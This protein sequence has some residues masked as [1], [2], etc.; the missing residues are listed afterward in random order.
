MERNT[1]TKEFP[2]HP[3]IQIPNA[4][5]LSVDDRLN[6][7]DRPEKTLVFLGRIH[8]K[9]GVDLLIQAFN[10]ADLE[11]NWKLKIIGPDFDPTY[12]QKLRKLVSDLDLVNRVEFTGPIYGNAKY[13]M[14]REAW[15]VVVPSYSEVVALVNLESAALQTPTITTTRTG[16]VDWTDSGGILIEPIV[17]ELTQAILS[18]ASWTLDERCRRGKRARNFIQERYSWQVVG[19]RW[20]EAYHQ[21][22]ATVDKDLDK[23]AAI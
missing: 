23:N 6:S 2:H 18:A 7:E 11:G 21:I 4:I 13:R 1:L 14:M 8:P 15:V 5:D 9:K 22:A 19:P 17:E 10:K 16:L 12:G 3:Q 20:V